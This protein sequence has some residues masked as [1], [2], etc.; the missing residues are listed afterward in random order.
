MTRWILLWHPQAEVE[1]QQ[2]S[3]T[4]QS[5]LCHWTRQQ[6]SAGLQATLQEL[7]QGATEEQLADRAEELDGTHQLAH[8]FYLLRGLF[9]KALLAR[10]LEVDGQQLA[11]LV[12]LSRPDRFNPG[13]GGRHSGTL[14]RLCRFA[15]ARRQ[16]RA[17]LLESPLSSFQVVVHGWQGASL[18]GVLA[19]PRSVDELG[20]AIPGLPP[21]AAAALAG[22]LLDAQL[23][24]PVDEQGK[25]PDE[26]PPRLQWEFHDLF[27]HSRSRLG[28]HLNPVGATFPFASRVPPVLKPLPAPAKGRPIDLH[29][30]DLDE[31]QRTDPPYCQVQESRRS[32]RSYAKEPLT[33]RQIGEFLFRVAR[34]R[35]TFEIG[36]VELSS[37]P[38][39]GGGACHPLE[40]Y[41]AVRTC[42]GLGAG[43][44]CYQP[45]THRL[46]P[47][48]APP[49]ALETLFDS[50]RWAVG[51]DLDP[52]LMI[53]LTARFQ[54]LSWKYQSVVYAT[55]L[56]EVGV[57]M[58]TMYLC[59]TAMGLAGCALGSGDSRL[60]AEAAGLDYCTESSLG[61]F[62]L[63][64]RAP[65][66]K[67]SE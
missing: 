32:I 45:A 26:S 63:G 18:L 41:L 14:L 3:V 46:C 65:R 39:P 42:Q 38:Y 55:I 20:K 13:G 59:A 1:I 23:A 36:E 52:Q 4:V 60:F 35:K 58:Q 16:G 17:L 53:V 50:A 27:F 21:K 15:C 49:E 64:S 61:E 25:A 5:P 2:G 48:E 51:M 12:P 44:F 6:L 10:R 57:V 34:L 22:L 33:V 29:R 54:R 43:L 19:E 11:T 62:L 8:F 30:P 28:W 47:L 24:W 56:K 37:R 7:G 31:L 9:D 67:I 66:P 40:F